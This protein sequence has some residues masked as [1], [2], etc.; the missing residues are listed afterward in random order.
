MASIV[1]LDV[2]E[3]DL[4]LIQKHFPDAD[5]RSAGMTAEEIKDQC[6][7]AEIISGFIAEFPR[8]L[9]E[10]LPALKLLCTRTVGYDHID[11]DACREKGITVCN[12]PDYGSHVIAEYVF[13]LLLSAIRHVPEGD[14]RVKGGSY[15]YHGLCGTALKGK[16]IGILGTGKIG[17]KVA[18]MA[19]GF[20][21][22]ILATDQCRTT[23]LET[24]FG[25]RYVAFEQLLAESDILSLHLP[26]TDETKHLFNEKTFAMMKDGAIL[27]NTARGALIDS[28]ALLKNLENGK[29]SRALLDVLEHEDD[30]SK[31]KELIHHPK[32]IATPHVAFYA[33]DSMRNMFLESFQSIE[34]WK[35]GKTPDHVIRPVNI[36]CDLPPV[37]AK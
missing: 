4:P 29:I 27:V 14:A 7:D 8:S 10:K 15:D 36:V 18:R 22:K 25:V 11:L 34:Q 31:S 12:V 37:K 2:E 5:C 1:F 26:A 35:A 3:A 19:H 9:I 6:K 28:A 16:T 32:V 33:D 21:M 23:E 24:D 30:L 13:A 17:R 20:E